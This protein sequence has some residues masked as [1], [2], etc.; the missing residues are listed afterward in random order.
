MFCARF[1]LYKALFIAC[2][3]PPSVR[4]MN[5]CWSLLRH[6]MWRQC[7]HV[8]INSEDYASTTVGCMNIN[9][10]NKRLRTI[11]LLISFVWI[12]SNWQFNLERRKCACLLLHQLL[13]CL[14]NITKIIT[15]LTF[16]VDWDLTLS[17]RVCNNMYV[18][19]LLNSLSRPV[20]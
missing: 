16:V 12:F 11:H 13:R 17:V 4:P 7:F 10:G 19:C 9:E 5:W 14:A 18:R 6:G 3:F 8:V 2:L 20:F 15:V 1:I